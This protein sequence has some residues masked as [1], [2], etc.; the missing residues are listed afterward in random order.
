MMAHLLS[1][2]VEHGDVPNNLYI[3]EDG[4]SGWIIGMDMKREREKTKKMVLIRWHIWLVVWNIF[5]FPGQLGIIIPT[6]FHIF[7]RGWNHQPD[8]ITQFY[9]EYTSGQHGTWATSCHFTTWDAP[10]NGLDQEVWGKNMLVLHLKFLVT[11]WGCGMTNKFMI[12]GC[13]VV[14]C[15]KAGFFSKKMSWTW[16]G[17]VWFFLFPFNKGYFRLALQASVH[18]HQTRAMILQ[19]RIFSVAKSSSKYSGIATFHEL[20]II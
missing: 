16:F 18:T 9:V 20:S 1:W 11:L 14:F 8:I 4:S 7:Q 19:F 10:P 15:A 5:L 2:F 17:Y 13:L 12:A 6:G 3:K